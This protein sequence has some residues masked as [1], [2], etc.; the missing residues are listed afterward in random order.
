MNNNNS[1]G[2]GHT[3]NPYPW[4]NKP[5]AGSKWECPVCEHNW[6]NTYNHCPTCI[7]IGVTKEEID[8]AKKRALLGLCDCPLENF[9]N[10][11]LDGLS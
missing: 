7:D 6:P 9:C 10:C 4:D 1:K 5:K 11:G 8:P 3:E 2:T